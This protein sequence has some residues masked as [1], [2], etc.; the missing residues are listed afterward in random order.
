MIFVHIFLLF[1]L[2][3]PLLLHAMNSQDLNNIDYPKHI[4]FALAYISNRITVKDAEQ[5]LICYSH[6]EDIP[7]AATLV[8]AH[9]MFDAMLTN[10]DT[11][12][13]D[14]LKKEILKL[15]KSEKPLSKDNLE[16]VEYQLENVS[17]KEL[18]NTVSGYLQWQVKIDQFRCQELEKQAK[19]IHTTNEIDLF[20]KVKLYTAFYDQD[21]ALLKSLTNNLISDECQ[22]TID[23]SFNMYLDT[24]IDK[25]FNDARYSYLIKPKYNWNWP[26][27][28]NWPCSIS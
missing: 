24:I 23:E 20:N 8:E 4:A 3:S 11:A 27:N 17:E 13:P 19:K 7:F 26:C 22:D 12:L 1:S 6:R 5:K 16:S 15:E 21:I 10:Q 9:H 28:L 25:T 14:L 2:T 18:Y